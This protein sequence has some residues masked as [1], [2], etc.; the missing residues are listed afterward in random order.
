MK[1]FCRSGPLTYPL[2]H[3]SYLSRV[4]DASIASSLHCVSMDTPNTLFQYLSFCNSLHSSCLSRVSGMSIASPLHCASIDI[5]DPLIRHLSF[6]N[7]LH[8]SY[9]SRVSGRAGHEYVLASMAKSAKK[10]RVR[11]SM[12]SIG[13]F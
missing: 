12:T 13:Q 6:S 4:S 8:S 3:S 7:S 9:L 5:P 11:T 10:S 1:I 2:L